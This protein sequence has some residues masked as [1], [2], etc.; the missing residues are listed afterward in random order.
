MNVWILFKNL[1]LVVSDDCS[2]DGTQ[3]VLKEYIDNKRIRL[4]LNE[5]NQGITDNCNQALSYCS[6]K[7]VCF[8]AGDDVML[9]NKISAQ[10]ALLEKHQEASMC[11]HPVN[12]FDS[13]SGKMLYEGYQGLTLLWLDVSAYLPIYL[14][15]TSQ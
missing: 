7:Y 5:K 12:V 8:F 11:Y 1:E 6:G 10:V 4:L 13:D 2:T 3:E 15:I 9:P 14:I